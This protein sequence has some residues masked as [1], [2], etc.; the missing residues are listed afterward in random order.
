[1]T[2]KKNDG[3]NL[4]ADET[5]KDTAAE[6]TAAE[7][8]EAP[9]EENEV[10]SKENEE[11]EEMKDRYLRLMAEYD[12]FRKRTAKEREGVYSAAKASVVEQLLPVFDNIERAV[13]NPTTDDAYKKG[14]ELIMQQLTAVFEKLG[15]TEIDA[16]G[17][18]FDPEKHNA[19]AHTEDDA[20]SANTVAE[21]FQ[22]GFEA[23]GKVIR[24]AVVRVAN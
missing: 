20:Y 4:A 6:Q 5:V 24:H 11:L 8:T 17:K 18:E 22:K 14:I 2:K 15:V 1:M 9:A 19:V 13:L 21:V 7:E 10:L 23:D 12:N 16:Q 3:E